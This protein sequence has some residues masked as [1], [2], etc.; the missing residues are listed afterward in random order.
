MSAPSLEMRTP[1]ASS[2][3]R[4]T[5]VFLAHRTRLF[6]VASRVTGDPSTAEDVVQEAWL[7]WQ[8]VDRAGIQNPAA[9]LTTTTTRLA[10]N[11]IQ[12]ARHRHET[13]VGSPLAGLADPGLDPAR[14]AEQSAAAGRAITV[15]MTR[16]GPAEL[17]AYVL[18]K[19][20]DYAYR[21]IATLLRTSV[22][23]ARQLVRRGQTHLGRGRERPVDPDEHRVL[24]AAFLHAARSGDLTS[25]EQALAG[26]GCVGPA[27]ADLRRSSPWGASPRGASSSG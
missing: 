27:V 22:P 21:D 18:R 3:D 10:I 24:T 2:L 26:V 7:R 12:S 4:A 8:R 16:L 13:P 25:L 6:R 23:N 11:V 20:F 1:D 5:E 14:H 9:F 15:L 19:G 17:A